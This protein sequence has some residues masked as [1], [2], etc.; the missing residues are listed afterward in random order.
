MTKENNWYCGMRNPVAKLA[1]A[2][3][4]DTTTTRA[5]MTS[6]INAYIRMVEFTV[7]NFKNRSLCFWSVLICKVQVQGMCIE[8]QV[9]MH[10][11]FLGK[12]FVS[13]ATHL[14][15]HKKHL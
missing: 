5:K 13:L 11:T 12:P 3:S 14:A 4:I 8:S 2:K 10:A 15:S 7:G 1:K 6:H 9:L